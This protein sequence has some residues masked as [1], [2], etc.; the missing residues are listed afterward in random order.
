MPTN[1]KRVAR[2]RRAEITGRQ[3]EHLIFGWCLAVGHEYM[4]LHG[5]RDFPFRDEEHRRELWFAHKDYIM[6]MQ[7]AER[8]PGVFG[9]FPLR[10]GQKPEA[11]KDYEP[12]RKKKD[13]LT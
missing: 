4:N 12:K 7:G 10:K 2:N 9:A 8:I 6:S 11:W 13:V 1:R 3:L 5:R